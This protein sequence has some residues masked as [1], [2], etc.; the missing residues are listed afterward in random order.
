MRFGWQ[1]G[2][3]GKGAIAGALEQIMIGLHKK[4]KPQCRQ[5]PA[6]GFPTTTNIVKLIHC[7]GAVGIELQ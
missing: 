4:E 7:L 3:N 2:G 1:K 6:C 5:T